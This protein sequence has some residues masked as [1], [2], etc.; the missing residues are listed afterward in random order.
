MK[1]KYE[2]LTGETVE[3]EVPENIEQVLIAVD[4]QT[5]NSNRRETRRHS[6]IEELQ[7]KG[8]HL[9][10]NRVNIPVIFEKQ[11]MQE[12]L[13]HALN[14]LLPQQRELIKKVFYEGMSI[15]E[16]ARAEGVNES[17]IREQLNRT[18]KKLKNNLK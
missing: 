1:I 6:S 14:K 10:D 12:A 15:S 16:I 9:S 13:Y 2:F 18:Y 7:E 8:V 4:K 3:I 5:Q 17:S 11:E